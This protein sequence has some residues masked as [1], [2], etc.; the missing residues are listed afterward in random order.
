MNDL[1]RGKLKENV[2][3]EDIIKKYNLNYK[4]KRKKTYNFRVYSYCL[5]FFLKRNI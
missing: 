2:K 1:I 5:L 4:S 3:L